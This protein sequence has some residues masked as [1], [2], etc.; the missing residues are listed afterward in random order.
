M[1]IRLVSTENDLLSAQGSIKY[2]VRM[3]AQSS[4]GFFVSALVR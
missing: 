3:K 2:P 1:L 4:E